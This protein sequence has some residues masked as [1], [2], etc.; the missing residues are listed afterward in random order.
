MK[1]ERIGG[2]DGG[3]E[4]VRELCPAHIKLRAFSWKSFFTFFLLPHVP[5]GKLNS[6]IPAVEYQLVLEDPALR[7]HI[8][9]H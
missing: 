5:D 6:G 8:A 9:P 4:G 7:L 2:E 1:L 3:L